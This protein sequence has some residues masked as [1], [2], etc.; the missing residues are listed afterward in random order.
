MSFPDMLSEYKSEELEKDNLLARKEMQGKYPF[1]FI[2]EGGHM[3]LDN[4][5]T[6]IKAQFG[7]DKVVFLYYGKTGYDFGFA[8]YF[9][10]RQD[11]A[12]KAGEAVPNIY[13]VYPH[14]LTPTKAFR[15]IGYENEIECN[16]NDKKAIIFAPPKEV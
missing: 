10:E 6:W 14:S 11:E 4:L 9:F 13:T 12:L 15:S 1:S 8:E 7:S 5:E 2:V 16:P 3:E